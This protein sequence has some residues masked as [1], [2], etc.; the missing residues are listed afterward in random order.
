MK[1]GV[2]MKKHFYS[3]FCIAVALPACAAYAPEPLSVNH[4][5]HADALVAPRPS[6]S[7]TLAYTRA[8]VVSPRPL[9]AA[10]LG[11]QSVTAE[12]KVIATVPS[13]AQLVVE[14]GE[15]KGFMEAMTMGY[16]VEPASLMDGVK[17]GDKIRFTID[18]PK[19]AIVNLEIMK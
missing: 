9:A 1:T 18:V 11:G 6:P 8:E 12:G 14:H 2:D 13:A 3:L 15:I 7:R 5:A 19:K 4:P 10:E 17:S 16:R